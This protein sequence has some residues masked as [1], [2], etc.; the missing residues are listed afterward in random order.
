MRKASWLAMVVMLVLLVGQAAYAA[1]IS[2]GEATAMFPGGKIEKNATLNVPEQGYFGSEIFVRIPYKE[3]ISGADLEYDLDFKIRRQILDFNREQS[4]A[5]VMENLALFAKGSY[6]YGGSP[7]EFDEA[8]S[9]S[10]VITLTNIVATTTIDPPQKA[11]VAGGIVWFQRTT[12]VAAGSRQ[13]Y[14]RCHYAKR[15]GDFVA[16]LDVTIP[17]PREQ[18]DAWFQKLIAACMR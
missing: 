12:H 10:G 8:G 13:E 2:D 1:G 6:L 18:A 4:E 11:A 3:K 16:T 5:A 7:L 9:T 17:G 15:V 14:H